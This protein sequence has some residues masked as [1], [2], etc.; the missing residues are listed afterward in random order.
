MS[1]KKIFLL[2]TEKYNAL[3]VKNRENKDY[4]SLNMNEKNQ[5][6]NHPPLLKECYCYTQSNKENR[7]VILDKG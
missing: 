3:S 2:S 1:F 4:P 6:P 5:S 7:L